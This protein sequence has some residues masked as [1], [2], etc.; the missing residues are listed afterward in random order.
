R[1]NEP[2]GGTSKPWPQEAGA[3]PFSLTPY[4]RM[5]RNNS[6]RPELSSCGST[7]SACEETQPKLSPAR[8]G[9]F[10]CARHLPWNGHNKLTRLLLV[11]VNLLDFK[12]R[13]SGAFS[14]TTLAP[15]CATRP[16]QAAISSSL[17]LTSSSGGV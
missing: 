15:Q 17:L 3:F 2:Q 9:A 1:L 14:C 13:P 4:R 5:P 10:S 7:P 11:L 12:P 6:A 16:K 8:S